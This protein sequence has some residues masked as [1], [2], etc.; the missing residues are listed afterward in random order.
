MRSF[1]SSV[2]KQPGFTLIEGLIFL[3]LFALITMVFFQTFA[4]GTAL[5]Q[6]SKN[7]LGA[8][9]LAN[10]KMEIIRSLD[11]NS[12]GTVT[13]IPSGDLLEDEAVQVN[14]SRYQVHTFVQYADDPYDGTLGGSPNDLVPNDYKRARV[15]VSWG[16]E[17]ESEKVMLFSTFAPL[18]IEQP[19]GGGILSINIL[20]SQ[21]N[22]LSG[23]TVH[24]TNS[25]VAPTVDVTTTTDASGN[26]FL[27]GAPA[28]AQ[29]YHVTFS[30][31]GYFGSSTYAPFPTT[32]F[33]PIDVHASVVDA[34]VNQAS[35][36]MD[37]SSTLQ[38]RTK[39]PFD[40]AVSDIDYQID[41]GRQIGT[42]SGTGVAVHD[43]GET[44][45]T[46]TNGEHDYTNRSYGSYTWTLDTGE[47]GHTFIRLSPE[48]GS[49][50][51]L[52]TIAPNVT[53][54]VQ[55]I[56]A[57]NV[58]NGVLFTVT[59]SADGTAVSSASVHLTNT[60]LAYDDTVTTST[61]GKAYFPKTAAPGMVADT[62]DYEITASGLVTST[63]TVTVTSG[64]ESM[65]I[66][67]SP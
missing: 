64:L 2:K 13:G 26:L 37:Q 56:L 39:D 41:G 27:V 22:G 7:R 62:Y 9:A 67:M 47:T 38:L 31:G 3:F 6:Q 29:E 10:Q 65:S 30:K 33:I 15:E 52:I 57:D 21:G 32:A 54:E 23:A 48:S 8:L 20:D 25:S 43:F 49:G 5:I 1:G 14:N 12:I 18:G 61:Y 40:V 4:F 17:T 44:A 51:N 24:I 55:M 35:F 19:A 11:Y 34:V 59:N 63:G 60:A 53:Q 16:N 58:V 28:S 46:D 42:E 66:S 36:V 50:E 45:S